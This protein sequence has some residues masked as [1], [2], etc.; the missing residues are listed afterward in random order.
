MQTR[1]DVSRHHIGWVITATEADT[2]A[3]GGRRGN[4]DGQDLELDLIFFSVHWLRMADGPC[5]VDDLAS[6]LPA[7][8]FGGAA[9]AHGLG[10][11]SRARRCMQTQGR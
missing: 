8:A 7:P 10:L 2:V 11:C 1:L 9:H 3:K 4:L 6:D 5:H